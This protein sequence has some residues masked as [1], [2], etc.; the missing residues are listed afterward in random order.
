MR[1]SSAHMTTMKRRLKLTVWILRTKT[2]KVLC[3]PRIASRRWV[4]I[5]C[6]QLSRCHWK[7]MCQCQKTRILYQNQ[8]WWLIFKRSMRKLAKVRSMLMVTSFCKAVKFLSTK[9]C[10]LPMPSRLRH[11]S[12]HRAPKRILPKCCSCASQPRLEKM[13][14]LRCLTSSQTHSTPCF[15]SYTLVTKTFLLSQRAISVHSRLASSLPSFRSCVNT[16]SP[17]ISRQTQCWTFSVSAISKNT[18]KDQT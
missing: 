10:W 8:H 16:L 1:C 7:S 12:L 5:W 9:R 14:A 18:R 15:A 13:T 17:I 6:K 3:R 4:W 11:C 2:S